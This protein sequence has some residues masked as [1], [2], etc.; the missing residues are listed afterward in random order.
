MHGE[1]VKNG[2]FS[3]SEFVSNTCIFC[4]YK[5]LH[6]SVCIVVSVHHVVMV[7]NLIFALFSEM[8]RFPIGQKQPGVL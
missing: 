4:V 6:C 1:T 7:W 3:I 8:S 2:K 5:L